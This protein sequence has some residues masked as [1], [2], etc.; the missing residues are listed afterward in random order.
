VFTGA[1]VGGVGT[2]FLGSAA[3]CSALAEGMVFAAF[4]V[5]AVFAVFTAEGRAASDA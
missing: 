2:P 5:L 4:T 1:P 3:V